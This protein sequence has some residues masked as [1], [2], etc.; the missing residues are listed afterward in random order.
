MAFWLTITLLVTTFSS[1]AFF[2]YHSAFHN[3][4]LWRRGK[5]EAFLRAGELGLILDEN[6]R[7][8]SGTLSGLPFH[9]GFRSVK[10]GKTKHVEVW[11]RLEIGETPEALEISCEDV[12]SGVFRAFGSEELNLEDPEFDAAFWITGADVEKIKE[13]L[14]PS[15]RRGM[16]L[17][18]SELPNAKLKNGQ[19]TS[20]RTAFTPLGLVTRFQRMLL[21]F[22]LLAKT[23]SGDEQEHSDFES[24]GVVTKKV[25]RFARFSL[26]VF[27]FSCLVTSPV[28]GNLGLLLAAGFALG[29]LFSIL[30]MSSGETGRVL[31]QS[32][33]AFVTLVIIAATC[34]ALTKPSES[35]EVIAVGICGAVAGVFTWGGRHYLKTLDQTGLK[36]PTKPDK[37]SDL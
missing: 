1:I 20:Y 5:N 4:F 16:L 19:I 32:Y 18:M 30:A 2:V 29:V 34:V 25:R 8:V 11:G 12:L 26:V 9:C 28:S 37:V 15:I 35:S 22:S 27:T 31:L 24:T 17:G 6:G 21:Q 13:F 33:Y 14:T 3:T 36:Q 23:F 10:S 7:L